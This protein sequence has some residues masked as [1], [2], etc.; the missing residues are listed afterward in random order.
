MTVRTMEDINAKRNARRK[1]ILENSE[2]RLSKITGRNEDNESEAK[3][4]HLDSSSEIYSAE[5]TEHEP[6]HLSKIAIPYFPIMLGRLYNYKNTKEMQ[7]NNNLLYAALILCNIKPELTYQLKK[8][9]TISH[10]IVG[11]VALYIFSFTLI[12][13]GFFNCLYDT[14]SPG[15]LTV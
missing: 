10:M 4:V 1:R 13:Y 12:Y 8:L 5:D 15:T 7:E 9:I 6:L 3:S 11:D 2:K 14:D